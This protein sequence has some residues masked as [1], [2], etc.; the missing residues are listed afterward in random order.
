MKKTILYSLLASGALVLATGCDESWNASTGTQGQFNPLLSLDVNPLSSRGGSRAAADGTVEAND[1]SLRLTSNATGAVTEWT[2]VADYD[3]STTFNIG[4]YTLEAFYGDKTKE[5]FESPYYYGATTF[6]IKENQVT[7]VSLQASLA[8]TMISITY[9]EAFTNYFTAYGAEIE[10]AGRHTLTYAADETRPIYVT[11]GNTS[12]YVNVTRP[13]GG[14]VRLLAVNQ[15][16]EV[17]HHYNAVIDVNGGDVNAAKL[18]ITFDDQCETDVTFDILLDDI[19]GA[20]A[21][22][23]T[24]EGFSN[25]DSYEVVVG[26][27]PDNKL[28]YIA[29]APGQLG[30]VL[31]ETSSLALT[32]QGW[33]ESVE[34]LTAD[35]GTRNTMTSMGFA[36]RGLWSNPDKMAVVDLTNVIKYISYI[37][38]GEN[39]S[40]FTLT[41]TDRFGQK[42][43]PVTFTINTVK[44]ILQLSNPS[45]INDMATEMTVDLTYNGADPSKEVVIDYQNERG[46]WNAATISNVTS[47][48]RATSV[49][50]LNVS[51]L[52]A[53]HADVTL[54]ARAIDQAGNTVATS[55]QNV[56]VERSGVPPYDLQA[57]N[58]LGVFS[59]YA[60]LDAVKTLSRLETALDEVTL[61]MSANG[62]AYGTYNATVSGNSLYVQGLAPATTYTARLAHSG[63]SSNTVT[64]TTESGAQLQNG[65]MDDG[66]SSSKKSNA[67]A[68]CQV[69]T[70][71]T[72]WSTNNG[73]TTGSLKSGTSYSGVSAVEGVSD[74]HSG[75]AARISTV[76]YGQSTLLAG[77]STFARGEMIYDNSHAS[78][79]SSMS[80]Y[81]KY[82]AYSSGETGV[83]TVTVKDA[84]GN[85]IASGNQSISAVANYTLHTIPLTYVANCA[86]ASTIRVELYSTNIEKPSESNCASNSNKYSY[87]SQLYI[88]DITL[89]Y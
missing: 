15:T 44:M 86:K 16:L 17:R 33:P 11:P 67:A 52:P 13:G 51:G 59:T 35:G 43:D 61:E 32:R 54:R 40:K 57:V 6:T 84:S 3:P 85:V 14:D 50:T 55:L 77:P 45:V 82:T 28:T 66:W 64:F 80:F 2:S 12:I 58:D 34:L 70:A 24:A 48:A 88:D 63:S 78:R 5:D 46:T 10:T 60:T 69:W 76:G 38:G 19:D 23:L 39:V 30:S 31:L 49:Y 20:Q 36:E 83:V 53:S 73:T 72:P 9:T 65:N 62:G 26:S 79:P 68:N 18:T 21:P 7:P 75:T 89:N 1:L 71:P 41:V 37:E 81:T 56:T 74:A 22:T 25:G 4:A 47:K 87:G 42:A 27:N 8:N 29:V